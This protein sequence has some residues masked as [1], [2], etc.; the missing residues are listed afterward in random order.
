VSFDFTNGQRHGHDDRDRCAQAGEVVTPAGIFGGLIGAIAWNLATW[1]FGL[2][3]SSSHAL[4]GGIVGSTFVAA[5]SGAI[6]T[7]G[8]VSKVLIPAVTSPIVAGLVAALGVLLA[9]RLIRRSGRR[10]SKCAHPKAS[11]PRPSPR[12]SS[13]PPPTRA[14]RCRRRRSSR[15]PSPG[16]AGRPGGKVNW[17][18]ARRIVYGWLFT[19]PAAAAVGAI[20]YGVI[21]VLGG[22]GFVVAAISIISVICAFTLWRANKAKAVEPEQTISES[23]AFGPAAAVR[24]GA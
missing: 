16:R 14:T 17:A 20:A 22:G 8:I 2:P 24:V 5:G 4:I 6:L 3:S 10:S 15:A 12:P 1:W 13:S 7:D 19:L 9:C 21:D 23:P 18:V 11:A